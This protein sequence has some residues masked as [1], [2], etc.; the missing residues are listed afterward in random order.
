[1]PYLDPSPLY[2]SRKE[3]RERAG[4]V[5]ILE[6]GQCAFLYR[7]RSSETRSVN[8]VER[9]HIVLQPYEQRLYRVLTLEGN[10]LPAVR[11]RG[12]R[13][14][15]TIALWRSPHTLQQTLGTKPKLFNSARMA[16]E[17][18]YCLVRHADHLHVIH[19]LTLPAGMGHVQ[20][21]LAI[22]RQ[23]S[24]ILGFASGANADESIEAFLNAKQAPITF[25]GANED[26]EHE[27][28]ID[29]EPLL[30]GHSSKELRKATGV[31]TLLLEPMFAGTWR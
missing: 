27:L 20:R 13:I 25:V 4:L 9:L 18:V 14:S 5:H 3:K 28:G 7:P 15:G 22:E 24:Y 30:H 23:G 1:M 6:S 31:K 8:D 26:I 12:E 19:T 16:A 17:G 11:R 10:R 29:L 2:L 21:A